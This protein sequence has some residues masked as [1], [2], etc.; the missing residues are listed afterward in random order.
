MENQVKYC[1]V[2]LTNHCPLE[3]IH[4]RHQPEEIHFDR[5]TTETEIMVTMGKEEAIIILEKHLNPGSLICSNHRNIC[6]RRS[7]L[8]NVQKRIR[9]EVSSK[10]Q[11][12]H[13]HDTK[14]YPEFQMLE[15][16]KLHSNPDFRK[17]SNPWSICH[18]WN[19]P[20]RLPNA[21]KHTRVEVNALVE[22]VKAVDGHQPHRRLRKKVHHRLLL[23]PNQPGR[24]SRSE[25]RYKHGI[26][27]D[28]IILF[29]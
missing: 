13:L 20:L 11:T 28:F 4:Q 7:H 6:H 17:C 15:T 1:Q 29:S 25:A 3:V 10:V 24:L 12:I 22:D 23:R 5:I 8:R 9:V 19:T 2:V 18:L 26:V 16:K 27:C 21:K 14:V